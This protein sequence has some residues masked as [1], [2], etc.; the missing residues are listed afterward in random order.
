MEYQVINLDESKKYDIFK[1]KRD[2]LIYVKKHEKDNFRSGVDHLVKD[3]SFLSRCCHHWGEWY[4]EWG[5]DRLWQRWSSKRYLRELMI[6]DAYGRVVNIPDLAEEAFKITLPPEEKYPRYSPCLDDG[7][8]WWEDSWWWT[9]HYKRCKNAGRLGYNCRSKKHLQ[10]ERRLSCDEMHKP[11][12]RGKRTKHAL[13]PWGWL[14]S[15]TKAQITWK[16]MKIRKQWMEH[17]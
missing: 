10:Q 15:R 2:L 7:T 12:I 6:I 8:E 17:L 1:S 13:N 16:Q 5:C 4:T 3:N 9:L 11:F 14:E